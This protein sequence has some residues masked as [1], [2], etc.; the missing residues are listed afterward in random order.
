MSLTGFLGKLFGNKSQRDLKEIQPIVDRINELGPEM[1]ALSNDELRQ[2]ITDIRA[3]LAASYA[4]DE[5]A[6]A[7]LKEEVENLPFD[8]R[9]PVWDKIDAHEK[10]IIDTLD[11]ELDRVLPEVFAAMREPA[12]RFAKNETI[13]VN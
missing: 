2:K 4:E 8:Q 12:S 5:A 7:S 11:K 9:Q 10:N 13:E 1:Q 3:E 6:V